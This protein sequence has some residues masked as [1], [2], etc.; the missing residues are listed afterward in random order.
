M[1]RLIGE[2]R[3]GRLADGLIAA[4][5]DAGEVLAEHFPPRAGDRD[6]LANDVVIL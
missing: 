3:V 6:E 5:E 2:V 4:V 1:D